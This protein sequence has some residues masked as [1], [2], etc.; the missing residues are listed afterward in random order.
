MVIDDN[1][2]EIEDPKCNFAIYK[3]SVYKFL[4]DLLYI[5]NQ[6]V[7]DFQIVQAD[8]FEMCVKII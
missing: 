7:S 8:L 1:W 2:K 6:C 5:R 3:H 4:S